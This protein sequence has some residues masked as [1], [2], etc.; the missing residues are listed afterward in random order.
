MTAFAN[1]ASSFVG[2]NSILSFIELPAS[3]IT[4]LSVGI[5]SPENSFENQ[6]PTSNSFS[7]DKFKSTTVRGSFANLDNLKS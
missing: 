6:E 1:F 7:C 4:S 3:C 2:F 5:F